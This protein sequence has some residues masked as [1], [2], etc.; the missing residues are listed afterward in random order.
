MT[1]LCSALHSSECASSSHSFDDCDEIKTVVG[2]EG[3]GCEGDDV[4]FYHELF[5]Y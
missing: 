2:V 5:I 3:S 4:I 1:V